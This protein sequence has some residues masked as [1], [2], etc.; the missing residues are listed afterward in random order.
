M[1]LSHYN[2]RAGCPPKPAYA[3]AWRTDRRSLRAT[4]RITVRRSGAWQQARSWESMSVGP[5]W[6]LLDPTEIKRIPRV[7]RGPDSPRKKLPGGAINIF[8][9]RFTILRAE[10]FYRRKGRERRFMNNE[11]VCRLGLSMVCERWSQAKASAFAKASAQQ[12]V[13]CPV[14]GSAAVSN[15]RFEERAMILPKL[16]Q[17]K[18]GTFLQK[19]TEGT[20][21]YE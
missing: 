9:M 5:C 12:G 18:L 11:S 10:H 2:L 21:V 4:C 17:I 6:A 15:L 3:M 7:Q 19:G 1:K 20:K 14:A 13:G 16:S 8:D